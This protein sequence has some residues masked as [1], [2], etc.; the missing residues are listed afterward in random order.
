LGVT[1]EIGVTDDADSLFRDILSRAIP[2]ISGKALYDVS[3][4][5]DR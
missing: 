2:E 4:I 3:V 1:L 5:V